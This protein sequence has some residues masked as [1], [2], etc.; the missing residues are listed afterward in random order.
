MNKSSTEGISVLMP[1]YNQ[2]TFISRAIASL[3]C[4]TF[5]NW[6]LIIINDGST[7]YTIDILEEYINDSKI[8]YYTNE[9]NEGLGAALNT[10]LSLSTFDLIAYLPSD[11]IYFSKHLD[12]LYTTLLSSNNACLAF[13]GLRHDYFDNPVSSSS[14]AS[15]GKI[16]GYPMQLVQVIHKKTDKKWV[17]RRELVT[18][19]LDKMFWSGLEKE[20]QFIPTNQIT[21]EWVDHPEQRHKLINEKYSGGIYLYKRFYNISYPIKFKSITGIYVNE[22]EEYKKFRNPPPVDSPNKL[23]ILLV[24]ELAYNSERIYALEQAGHKLYGLW[25][26]HPNCYNA[27]GPL[28]FGNV[29]DINLDNWVEKIKE[30]Q[31]DIIYALLN[32]QAVSL[33]HY[34]MVANPGIPFVWHFKEGPF[35]SR[36]QGLWKELIELYVN[37]D[38]QIFT[39][40]EV[41]QWF[42]QFILNDKQCAHILDG[43]LPKQDWFRNDKTLLLSEKDG[44]IHTVVPGRPMGLLP[45][46]IGQLAKQK[47]HLH[48]YGDIQQAFWKGWINNV[49]KIAP[50]FVHLHPHCIPQN[51]VKELSKY[52]AGW[53]HYFESENYGELMMASWLDLNYPARISTL[54]AAG[55]PMLQKDNSGHIAATHTLIE[56]WDM[57]IFFNSFDELGEKLRNKTRMSELRENV[58]KNRMIFSFDYHVNDLV[59]FFRKVIEKKVAR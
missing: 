22:E 15:I 51:W 56:K 8:K 37:S 24:G 59:A 45:S 27:V 53:L 31:P 12:T 47:I 34:I 41:M 54:A 58:W 52:D 39:N 7:D 3:K 2:A 29:E 16:D 4:Q 21:C 55:L 6:E 18:D 26:S 13:S 28:P 57:G 40:N 25:I 48:L 42:N 46:H 23:K 1:T 33:A 10:A 30:I 17:E 9:K 32:Y 35:Y 5:T 19:D 50:G 36:Q 44:E 43:D 20:G 49:N 14:D 38:G 11:D